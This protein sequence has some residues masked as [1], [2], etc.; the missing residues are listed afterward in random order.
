MA[1]AKQ[2][3]CECCRSGSFMR[4]EWHFHI[5]KTN[6]NNTEGF[7]CWTT[8]FGFT[9][10]WVLLNRSAKRQAR[11]RWCSANVAK[12]QT[13]VHLN[14]MDRPIVQ[15]PSKFAF[16][17]KMLSVGSLPDG[18]IIYMTQETFSC[19]TELLFTLNHNSELCF[20]VFF[21]LVA[22]GSSRW[23][24]WASAWWPRPNEATRWR[25]PHT[26]RSVRH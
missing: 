26:L 13:S 9:S 6:K 25:T 23:H 7:S 4:T 3:R 14:V 17:F 18:W 20:T 8:L 1:V 21:S 19:S 11:G 12:S 2:I 22:S 15:S 24:P 10:N 5:R 16:P